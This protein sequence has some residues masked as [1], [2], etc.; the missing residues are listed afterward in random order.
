MGNGLADRTGDGFHRGL[1]RFTLGHAL[2][3]HKAPEKR[4]DDPVHRPQQDGALA[5]DIASVLVP[6]RRE[7]GVWCPDGHRPADGLIRGLAIGVLYDREAGID[8]GA[9]DLLPLHVQAAHRR[10]HA[11]GT[12][13]DDVVA[14]GKSGAL[15]FQVRQQK[16]VRQA[17][18]SSGTQRREDFL[19]LGCLGGIGNEQEHH[20]RFANHVVHFSEGAVCLRETGLLRLSGGA[21]V[22]PQAHLHP[23]TGAFQR[24]PQVLRLGGPL[25]TPS[26]DADLPDALECR[27]QE[28][29]F[30]PAASHN[31]LFGIPKPDHFGFKNLGR[32]IPLHFGRFLSVVKSIGKSAHILANSRSI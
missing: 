28:R 17:Q 1:E 19:V 25:R 7:K 24:L 20:V 5:E 21:A 22:R 29:K 9:V 6:Q 31:S 3:L 18:G 12:D 10:P 30:V 11:L 26:D 23:D 2:L 15:V 14:G 4:L 16:A 27:R 32:K 8:T 13:R